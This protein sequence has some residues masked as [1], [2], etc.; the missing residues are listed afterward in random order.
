MREF[1]KAANYERYKWLSVILLGISLIVINA[2]LKS[3]SPAILRSA[4]EFIYGL[5]EWKLS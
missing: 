1:S 2:H 3:L 4:I 5:E